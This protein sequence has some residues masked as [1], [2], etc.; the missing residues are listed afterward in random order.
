MG[1]PVN[2]PCLAALLALGLFAC[3]TIRLDP[4]LDDGGADDGSPGAQGQDGGADPEASAGDSGS[5]S[6]P[7]ATAKDGCVPKCAG[8]ACGEDGCGGEC[9][10]CGVQGVCGANGQCTCKPS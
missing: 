10:Q 5:A 3:G 4:I 6:R 7:D 9:G 1:S 2:N 8:R